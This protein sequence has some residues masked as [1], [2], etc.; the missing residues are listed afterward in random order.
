M[1]L[2]KLVTGGQTGV[3]RG[4]LDAALEAQLPAGGWCPADRAAEDGRVPE[5]YPVTPLARGGYRARTL[6]NV[7]D[8]DGTAIL[9]PGALSGGTRLTLAFCQRHGKPVLVV[10]AS[11]VREADAAGELA[12]FVAH[13]QIRTLNVAGPRASGW[14]EGHTY[15][16]DTL[17]ALFTRVRAGSALR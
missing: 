15:A 11:R 10:D 13:H 7:Q 17:R 8:S 3:D 2:E 6:R 5:R 16:R 9:A 4:A 12:R 14:P 1:S